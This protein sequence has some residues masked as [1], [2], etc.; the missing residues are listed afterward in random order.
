MNGIVRRDV[1]WRGGC[2]IVISL[3]FVVLSGFSSLAMQR[4]IKMDANLFFFLENNHHYLMRSSQHGASIQLI[5]AINNFS[6]FVNEINKAH[7][8]ERWEKESD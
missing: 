8:T 3:L 1:M 5:S 6:K 4:R 7:T 2:S